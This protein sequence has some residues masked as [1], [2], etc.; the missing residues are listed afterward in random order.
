LKQEAPA[1]IGGSSSHVLLQGKPDQC[2]RYGEFRVRV[3]DHDAEIRK[4]WNSV[5]VEVAINSGG[6]FLRCFEKN[7]K[8]NKIFCNKFNFQSYNRCQNKKNKNL[9][10]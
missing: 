9:N 3:G 5:D 8:K 10:F 7:S 1:S 4:A 2:D 6:G